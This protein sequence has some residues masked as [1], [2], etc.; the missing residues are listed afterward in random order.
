[1]IPENLVH[2]VLGTGGF[3]LLGLAAVLIGPLLVRRAS[4]G[5]ML[6]GTALLVGLLLSPG[7]PVVIFDLTGLGR[8]LWRLTWA[9]PV[10]A[11]VGALATSIVPGRGIP[12]LRA[13]PALALCG[14]MALGGVAIWDKGGSALASRP[15]LKRQ[16]QALTDARA[17]M[18]HTRPGDV[19]LAP[20]VLSQTLLILSGELTTVSPR[21]FFTRALADVPAVHAAARRRLQ[22]FVVFGLPARA[23]RDRVR[24]LRE[25][26]RVVGVDV[27]CL[28]RSH[29]TARRL[30]TSFGFRRVSLTRAMAC[31]RAP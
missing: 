31:T 11:L 9:L 27:V 5:Q 6:A 10:A 16:P 24:A 15:V 28:R 8:V 13:A 2:Y 7:V 14:A 4:A 20:K 12:M 26:L 1:V 25:D 23:G 18:P 19:V 29:V 30:L 21:G 3:A 17:V 22:H